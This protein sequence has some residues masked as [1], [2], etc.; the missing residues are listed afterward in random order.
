MGLL[1]PLRADELGMSIVVIGVLVAARP[2]AE[3]MCAVPLSL[4]IARFGSRAAFV[5]GTGTCAVVCLGFTVA[6]QYWLLLALSAVVGA[7]RALAWVASQSYVSYAGTAQDR[8]RNTGR[9]SFVGNLSQMI[10]PLMVGATAAFAGYRQTFFL[11]AAY[12]FLFAIL[13]LALPRRSPGELVERVRLRAV[14]TLFRLPRLQVAFLLSFVRVAIPSIWTPF[15]PLL[16]VGAG[17]SAGKAGAVL[18]FAAV[19]ATAVNLATGWLSRWA[20]TEVLSTVSLAAAAVGLLLSPHLMSMPA[21]LLPA[22]LIGIGNGLSLPLL[23]VLF[24]EA[25]PAG[26]VPLALG[27]RNAVNSAATAVAP[28][29]VGTLVASLGAAIAFAAMSG[30]SGVLLATALGL[31]LRWRSGPK[32]REEETA[33][34]ADTAT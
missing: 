32:P 13:G 11:L 10:A 7:G 15:F 3:T 28:M 33:P 16:L 1:I 24:S 23:I 17:Y 8:A 27:A 26:Q 22:T 19:V 14:T 34:S 29:A 6:T 18:S 12:S 31:Y 9:F 20:S 2:L 4:L 25:A 30:F 5:I 21:V